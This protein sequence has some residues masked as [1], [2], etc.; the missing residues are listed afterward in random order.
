M[1]KFDTIIDVVKK[2]KGVSNLRWK[3]FKHNPNNYNCIHCKYTE[4]EN[5]IPKEK[6]EIIR[7]DGTKQTINKIRIV[8]GSDDDCVGWV[9]T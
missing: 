4:R 8:R 2:S 1:V 6:Y 5:S 9:G 3:K 7:P